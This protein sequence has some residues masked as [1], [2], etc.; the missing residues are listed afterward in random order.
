MKPTSANVRDAITAANANPGLIP[1][2][3]TD[4][5]STDEEDRAAMAA[6][7]QTRKSGGGGSKRSLP[8]PPIPPDQ[9]TQQ[10]DTTASTPSTDVPF[11]NST[12]QWLIPAI[13]GSG[14]GLAVASRYFGGGGGSRSGAGIERPI[15]GEGA[16]YVGRAAPTSSGRTITIDPDAIGTER[17]AALGGPASAADTNPLDAAMQRAVG[18]RSVAGAIEGPTGGGR[19][20]STITEPADVIY[21]QRNPPGVSNVDMANAALKGAGEAPRVPLRST[22]P[23][24]PLPPTHIG[25]IVRQI[26]RL[27]VR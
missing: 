22:G 16:E 12:A 13:L 21:P 4:R 3:V 14:A 6:A 25:E 9:S 11:D 24:T 26:L 7:G 18:G 20:S 23:R 10:T 15:V 27:G 19:T 2:L 17:R 8:T 5:P 1:G